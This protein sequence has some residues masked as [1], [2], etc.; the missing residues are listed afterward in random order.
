MSS[1]YQPNA[2]PLGPFG[3]HREQSQNIATELCGHNGTEIHTHARTHARTHSRTHKHTR[4]RAHRVTSGQSK[5]FQ[6]VNP[7]SGKSKNQSLHKLM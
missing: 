7:F 6:F 4:A 5:L 2:L 1:A 3:P